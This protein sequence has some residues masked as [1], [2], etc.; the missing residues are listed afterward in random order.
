MSLRPDIGDL[1]DRL[2]VSAQARM[3]LL[4]RMR[5]P[6]RH[7]HSDRH[8][9]LLWR[10]HCVFGHGG[11]FRQ[12]AIERL[13]ASAIAFHDAVL[14]PGHQGNEV[15]A[16]MLWRRQARSAAR[17]AP[18]EIEWVAVTIEAT[19]QHLAPWPSRT[20]LDRARV[21]MLDLDL[22]PLGERPKVFTGDVCRLRAEAAHLDEATWHCQR[23]RYLERYARASRLFRSPVLARVF[24]ARARANLQRTFEAAEGSCGSR[25]T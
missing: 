7:Y 9:A 24:E 16:A 14:D 18:A 6:G 23:L 17:L 5:A 13:I 25:P 12:P 22:T 20:L 15:E 4:R 8:L 2:P 3:D 11:P 10:R 21:W 19:A 1:L